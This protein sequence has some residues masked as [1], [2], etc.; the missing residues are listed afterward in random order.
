MSD[1]LFLPLMDA[2]VD[3]LNSV[4]N[5]YNK[6]PNNIEYRLDTN[7]Y[8]GDIWIPIGMKNRRTKQYIKIGGETSHTY[9]CGQTGSG[10]SNLV[11][12]ILS[13]IINNYPNV[14]L[15]LFDYKRVELSLFKSTR[16]C[17]VFEWD[18]DAISEGI[19]KLYQLVL[20]RYDILAEQGLTE[21]D[22]SMNS[23]LCV[24]EEISL[25]PKKDM[26]ILRKLMAISRGVHVYI[27]FTTQRPSNE[28]LDNVVKSL[29]GNRI[30]LKTD[31]KK[32]SVI[33]LDKVGCESLQGKGHGY[34]KA[35]GYIVEFQAYYINSEII[36][37]IINKYRKQVIPMPAQ[38]VQ[39]ENLD[40]WVEKL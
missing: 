9:I 27:L 38:N 5:Y 31:D 2:L 30:C 18:E 11:K 37:F 1:N 10:K 25:M 28:V 34:C 22:K 19:N 6:V 21:A 36:N 20:D 32:N 13:T 35:N 40:D 12:V 33:A 26:K 16:N 3:C 39:M 7:Y 23:I 24:I 4:K 8:L 14:R 15:Q 29:V 17:D